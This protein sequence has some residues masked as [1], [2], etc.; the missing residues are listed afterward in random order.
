MGTVAHYLEVEAPAAQCYA[1]WRGLTNLPQ[2]MPDVQSVEPVAGSTKVTH[3]KVSGPLGKTVE[4]QA[5]IVEDVENTRIAWATED[6][7][8]LEVKNAGAVRFDDHG[9]TTGVE[10]SLAY[11]PPAGVLGDAVAKLFAD[12]QDKVEKA[13]QAFKTTIEQATPSSGPTIKHT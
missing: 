5:H 6:S 13:L 11:D 9:G 1:W 12:P 10:V 4:W 7:G 2:I 3:W 8:A